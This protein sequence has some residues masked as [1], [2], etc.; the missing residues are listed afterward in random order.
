MKCQPPCWYCKALCEQ[1]M[2]APTNQEFQIY[3]SEICK[4]VALLYSYSPIFQ[5][6]TQANRATDAI[7]LPSNFIIRDFGFDSGNCLIQIPER[8]QCLLHVNGSNGRTVILVAA[9]SQ[10]EELYVITITPLQAGQGAEPQEKNTHTNVQKQL[11]EVI[12]VTRQRDK[13]TVGESLKSHHID[14][15]LKKELQHELDGH[16]IEEVYRRG[17][18]SLESLLQWTKQRRYC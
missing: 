3:C 9:P 4:N 7:E 8:H 2:K 16:L 15:S 13:L 1:C 10:T 14:S 6:V 18:E 5:I 12:S 11:F 17:F